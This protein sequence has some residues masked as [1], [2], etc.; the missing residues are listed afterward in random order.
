MLVVSKGGTNHI[1]GDVFD[2]LRNNVLDARNYFDTPFSAGLTAA[3][4]QRRLPPFRQNNFGGAAGGPIKKGKSFIFGVYEGIRSIKGTTELTTALPAGCR[5]VAG[6]LIVSGSA[7]N[8]CPASILPVSTVVTSSNPVIPLW[9]S[10][11]GAG[12]LAPIFPLPNSP[13]NQLSWSF[14]TITAENYGQARFDQTISDKD[15]MFFRYT[16]DQDATALPGGVPGFPTHPISVGQWGTLTENHIFSP[17]LLNT[18][19][20]GYSRDNLHTGGEIYY[21]GPGYGFIPNGPP[22]ETGSAGFSFGGVG[23]TGAGSAGGAGTVISQGLQSI[24]SYSDDL[25][26]THGNHAL[27]F[28]TLINH[29]DITAANGVGTTGTIA[30]S[31]YTLYLQGMANS[32]SFVTAPFTD[33][34]DIHFNTLGFYVQDDFKVN[35]KLTLNLGFRYEPNTNMIEIHGHAASVRNFLTDSQPTEGSLMM[36][37]PS[38]HN[39]SP[40]FGFAWDPWGNGKTSIRGGGSYLQ[41][42]ASWLGAAHVAVKQLPL[43]NPLTITAANSK[44]GE[45]F[46][47]P[48]TV[49]NP[50]PSTLRTPTLY[51]YYSAGQLPSAPGN[52]QPRG[53]YYN[54]SIQRQ[55]PSAMAATV[56]Y[57]GSRNWGLLTKDLANVVYPTGVPGLDSSGFETCVKGPSGI[58][59]A[60]QVYTDGKAN[61]CYF[62]APTGSGLTSDT[63]ANQNF[64]NITSFEAS[65]QSWYN[66]L[67]ASL[68][69]KV[70]RGLQFQA[71]FTWSRLLDTTETQAADD[72]GNGTSA[73]VLDPLHPE[74]DRGPADFNV[75]V[76][77]RFNLIYNT[78]K[79]HSNRIVNG[80]ANGWRISPIFQAQSGSA[81]DLG[82]STSRALP[83]AV[84]SALDRPDVYAGRNQSNITH[85]T[86]K[87]CTAMPAGTKLGTTAV[88]YDPCAFYVQPLGFEGN[89][90]RDSLRGPDYKTVDLS[91]VKDTRVPFL[92]EAG[93][94]E[95]RVEGFNIF[96][97]ANFATP[98]RTPFKGNLANDNDVNEPLQT[99]TSA[100]ITSTISSSRQVQM[101]LKILF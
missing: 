85:G 80:I 74:R 22:N 47:V 46:T 63:Y 28:G 36:E 86:S 98:G 90:G 82:L 48:F 58:N 57:T 45:P 73:F 77:F 23:I 69:K 91:F 37:D 43:E 44:V 13:N 6:Q 32:Y 15:N 99:A 89:M 16:V 60:D 101:V 30:F 3:G 70:T 42:V 51:Q 75:P 53:L 65:G 71:A 97:R 38:W 40:R 5:G 81:F 4:V 17:A 29:Y 25:Y 8:Q 68:E 64:G 59:P 33:R 35:P 67:Q 52:Q 2:F 93:N 62:T 10:P 49:P 41:N 1:H 76:T 94:A 72:G 27:K 26:Y 18:A 12:G 19:S 31:S 83:T 96:N 9:I 78:P 100:A 61:A 7:A 20:F 11:T 50:L 54:F 24:Y 79:L 88:Y 21:N 55:F 66:S 84:G 39:F 56:A 92:G 34:L 95:F 87:G 14:P